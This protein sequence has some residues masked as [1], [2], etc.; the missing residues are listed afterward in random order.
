MVTP[1]FA[2]YVDL[3]FTLFDRPLPT[4][5][6]CCLPCL[7][8]FGNMTVPVPTGDIPLSMSRRP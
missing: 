6:T 4:M 7:N 1:T 8:A 3:L 2:D 5:S